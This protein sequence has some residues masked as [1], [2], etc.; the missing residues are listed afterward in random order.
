MQR[1]YFQ[2][3]YKNEKYYILIIDSRV[4]QLYNKRGKK[5]GPTTIVYLSDFIEYYKEFK[6]KKITNEIEIM[7]LKLL[8]LY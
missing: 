5:V 2:V 7:K 6:M 1:E 3:E 8:G 4:S